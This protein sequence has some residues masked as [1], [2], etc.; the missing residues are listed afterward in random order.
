M[1]PLTPPWNHGSIPRSTGPAVPPDL[2]LADFL[3]LL[4]RV[5]LLLDFLLMALPWLTSVSCS[6]RAGGGGLLLLLRL[7]A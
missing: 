7:R 4:G 6:L 3:L 5:L 2:Y 1:F